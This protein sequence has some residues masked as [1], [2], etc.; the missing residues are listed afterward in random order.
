M[1][2]K[3]RRAIINIVKTNRKLK[4]IIRNFKIGNFKF[5]MEANSLKRMPYAYICFHAAV[6]AKKLGYERISVI[7]F[8]VGQGAGL[9]SLEE[10]TEEITKITGVNFDIYGF[11]TGEGLPKPN[12]YR[13]LPYQ[14]K[15]GFFSMNKNELLKKL[16]KS[17]LI[18]GNI[19]D[20]SKDFFSKYKPSPVGAIIHDFDFYSPTKIALNMM[21][22]NENLFL[23]RV[24]SYFDDTIGTDIELFN[25]YTGERLAINEFNLNSKDIKVTKPYHFTSQFKE[26][27]H[28]QIWIIHF[29]KHLKYNLFIGQQ[30]PKLPK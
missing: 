19:D 4:R 28:H 16:K 26:V 25:D 3:I 22:N 12:D 2:K 23:P 15:E 29:F 9:L 11:D 5:Q 13:D 30:N 20:T 10:Y 24:F 8:G 14:W 7:E 21:T 27:W 18:L 17:K 1:I 6:L